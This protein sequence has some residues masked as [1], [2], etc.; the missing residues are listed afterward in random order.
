MKKIKFLHN[1]TIDL[2]AVSQKFGESPIIALEN[3]LPHKPVVLTRITSR[4][5]SSESNLWTKDF[6]PKYSLPDLL[7]PPPG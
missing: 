3:E 6:P 1:R 5:G 2:F 7:S 4:L